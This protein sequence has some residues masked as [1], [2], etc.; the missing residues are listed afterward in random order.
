M[1]TFAASEF[2][3]YYQLKPCS[4]RV[5]L[6]A[7]G[8]APGEPDAYHKLLARLGER[9]ERRHLEGLG[10]HV[11]ANAS[12]EATREAVAK[13]ER[14]IYQAALRVTHPRCG[15]VV[16]VPDFLIRDGAGYLIRDCKLSRRFS[17]DFHPEIF[18]QLELYGWLYEE[19][20]GRPPIRLEAY[21]G[22]GQLRT[23]TYQPDRALA[24]LS[25]IQEVKALA[26]EPYDPIGWSKCLDCGFSEFCWGRARERRDV[27]QL[28]GVDQALAR[29]LRVERIETYDDLLARHTEATLAEI[30]KDVGGKPRR[31]T[32]RDSM[33]SR[34]TG[35]PPRC[36]SK[37]TAV[38]ASAMPAHRSRVG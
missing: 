26:E 24:A 32:L 10:E 8:V 20:F 19:T 21:M 11:N 27:A 28:P 18:R 16:G 22:D 34:Q 7:R 15:D 37:T 1:A 14:V 29:A 36:A 35:Q 38:S 12:V 2:H 30:K 5:Y 3:S 33:P 6:R 25:F 9:H 23:V 31:G 13:E 4:L 17:E